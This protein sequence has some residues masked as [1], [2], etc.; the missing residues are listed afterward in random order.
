MYSIDKSDFFSEKHIFTNLYN[1]R[2]ELISKGL[3]QDNVA[4]IG[5]K[6]LQK[7]DFTYNTQGWLTAINGPLASGQPNG[8]N[9]DLMDI[10][11]LKLNYNVGLTSVSGQTQTLD[12]SGKISKMFCLDDG[13]LLY[14]I[15]LQIL[16]ITD[17]K[18]SGFTSVILE[19]IKLLWM[20]NILWIRM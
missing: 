4:G 15:K 8:S 10:F 9:E 7:T 2:G 12:K 1:Y 20:V 11:Y 19:R 16:S 5:L 18:K 3:S 14:F 6:Y 13:L 17:L